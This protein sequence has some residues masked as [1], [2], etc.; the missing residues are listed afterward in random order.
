MIVTAFF[1]TPSLDLRGQKERRMP[2]VGF[3]GEMLKLPKAGTLPFM[4]E[5]QKGM[6]WN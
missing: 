1:Y 6:R 5:S 4:E 3:A 2:D